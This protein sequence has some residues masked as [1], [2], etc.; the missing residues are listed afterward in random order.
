M[1]GVLIVTRF[2]GKIVIIYSLCGGREGCWVL[3]NIGKEKSNVSKIDVKSLCC[4]FL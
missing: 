4:Y 3:K 2:L 1:G